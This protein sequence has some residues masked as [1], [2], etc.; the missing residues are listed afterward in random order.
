MLRVTVKKRLLHFAGIA[1]GVLLLFLLG[2]VIF[3]QEAGNENEAGIL[4]LVRPSIADASSSETS[5]LYDEAGITAFVNVGS[6]VNLNSV[7][8]SFNTIEKET[9]SYIIGSVTPGLHNPGSEDVHV[10]INTDGWFVAYYNKATPAAKI[11]DWKSYA[12][13]SVNTKLHNVIYKVTSPAGFSVSPAQIQ[14]YDFSNPNANKVMIVVD[15]SEFC[16]TVPQGVILHR[17]SASIGDPSL[18]QARFYYQDISTHRL[19]GGERKHCRLDKSGSYRRIRID[20]QVVMDPGY[21]SY[22]PNPEHMAFVLVYRE[23]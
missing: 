3:Q 11:V 14:M 17:A 8:S 6:S 2:G 15:Q 1:V 12:Q 7:R 4:N 20:G 22:Y 10:Y 18:S 16:V 19:T 5:F 9:G 21:L 13:G 23:N